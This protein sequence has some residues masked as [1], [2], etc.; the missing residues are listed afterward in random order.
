MRP[1]DLT[2]APGRCP[3]RVD[4]PIMTQ[5]WAGLTFLHW[6]FEPAE[7]QGL[8][9]P[10]LTAETLDGRAWVGLVP[11]FMRVG[12]AG[13]RQAPWVS[14]FCETNVR[15]YVLDEAG[16]SGIWFFSLD[17]AR[18][19]AVLVARA[20]FRLPYYWARMRL[21]RHG[22]QVRYRCRRRWPGPAAASD[23]T[24]LAGAPYQPGELTERDHFL[25]A[26]W[27]LFSVSGDRRRH[28]RAEHRPWPL[29]HAEVL[30]CDD[31]LL[32]AAGLTVPAGP[33]LVHYSDGVDVRIGRPE[34]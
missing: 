21:D 4:R 24:I 13:G 20:G 10:G 34:K 14:D 2:A 29:R 6:P 26:R 33:P 27:Q 18:L 16:R 15:T 12:T 23:V 28:A 11:F 30:S 1:D 32:T 31:R 25:T 19:G 8:L 9:P 7:V 3:F 17:A 5:R 22:D